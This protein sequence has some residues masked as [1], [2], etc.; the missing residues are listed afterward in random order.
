[1][2]Y[3]LQ[4]YNLF[5]SVAKLFSSDCKS[6]VQLKSEALYNNDYPNSYRLLRFLESL[7]KKDDELKDVAENDSTPSITNVV[8]E[9]F[10]PKSNEI[11]KYLQPLWEFLNGDVIDYI[12]YT[13]FRKAIYAA[14]LDLMYKIAEKKKAIFKPLT[15]SHPEKSL[16]LNCK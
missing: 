11:D 7:I 10:K 1:M 14:D 3:K 6:V 12:E 13:D 9:E 16:I 8:E 5:H 2:D 15:Q 4:R